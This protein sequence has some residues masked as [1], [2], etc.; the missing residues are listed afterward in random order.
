MFAGVTCIAATCNICTPIANLATSGIGCLNMQTWRARYRTEDLA[1]NFTDVLYLSH[2][3]DG[4]R[5]GWRYPAQIPRSLK[6]NVG[7]EYWSNL[8]HSKWRHT[9][10]CSGS[11]YTTGLSNPRLGWMN[12]K[13]IL[14]KSLWTLTELYA[15]QDVS[16]LT[17]K[18]H[19][20]DAV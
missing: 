8:K 19:G 1:I 2:I 13:W 11:S 12:A 20:T 9:D 5:R 17:G 7:V 6:T 14:S 3:K 18:R 4:G 10:V 15:A 16:Q